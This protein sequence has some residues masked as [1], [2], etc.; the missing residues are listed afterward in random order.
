MGKITAPTPLTSTHALSEFHCGEPVLDEWI[1]SRG[2]KSQASGAARTFVVCEE[3]SSQVVGFYSL[4]TGSVSHAVSPGGIRRNMPAP[5]PVIIIA[6][7]AVDG[8]CHGRGLGADLLH[9][10]IL[11]ICRVAENIG[12]RAIMVHALSEKAKQF[13][14]HHGFSVSLTQDRT[15]FLRVPNLS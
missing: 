12:V 15:L 4:A 13:Y 7:L 14:L 5:L 1:R 11:R 3:N 2:L 10:A 9:D 8:C 6:R